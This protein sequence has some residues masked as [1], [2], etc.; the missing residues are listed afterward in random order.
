MSKTYAHTYL[1]KQYSEYEKKMYEFIMSAERIDVNSDK[2]ADVLYDF[3]RRNVNS[4][5]VK[6]ITSKNVILGINSRGPLPKAFKVFV[7]KDVKEAKDSYRV[8][9]DVTDCIIEKNGQYICN[10][11]EWLI[12]YVIN[13]MVSYIYALNET[14]LTG[15]ASILR[16]GGIAFTKCLTY[17][18]DRMY[19]VSTVQQLKRRIDYAGAIYYQVNLLGKSFEK[20][21]DSIKANAMRIADIEPK[22]AQ[23]VD[24]MLEEKDMLNIDTFIQSLGKMF[25][26]KDLKTVNVVDVWMKGF[27]TG[28]IFALEYFP[29]F[30]AMLTNTY[31]GGYLDQQMTIEKIVGT[32]LVSFTKTIFQ[33]GASV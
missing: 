10:K 32:P 30:S 21:Y 11:L 4:N 17:T 13:A 24:I 1:F 14:R 8:F 33:I 23:I 27:G 15:N 5:L 9:I 7:A 20:N 19:K 2:F 25:N 28:T 3:K 29:A 22:D 31:V 6:I 18:I 12:S 16:D 26:L